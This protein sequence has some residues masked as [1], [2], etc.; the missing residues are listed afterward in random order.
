M[1]DILVIDDDKNVLRLVDEF[2]TRLGYTVKTANNGVEG[3]RL[4]A[5][6][7]RFRL[8]I[9]DIRMPGVDGNQVAKYLKGKEEM[10]N[11]PIIA[12][13]GYTDDVERG[14]FDSIVK[15]P[16]S[17]KDLTALVDSLS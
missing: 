6:N 15:K 10:K 16:F 13:S 7:R 9:T 11:T 8:V 12:V 5:E 1:G 2:L 4:L 3:I 17:L 14:L